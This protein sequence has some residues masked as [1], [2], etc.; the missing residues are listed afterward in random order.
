MVLSPRSVR[1]VDFYSTSPAADSGI[2]AASFESTFTDPDA[3][4]TNFDGQGN[5][6]VNNNNE[7]DVVGAESVSLGANFNKLYESLT[8]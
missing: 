2:D 4:I 3:T 5:L 7:G 1:S 8:R 6:N